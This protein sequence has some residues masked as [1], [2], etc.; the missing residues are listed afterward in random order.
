[1][2]KRSPETQRRYNRLHQ[3]KVFLREGKI[4][5]AKEYAQ[6]WGFDTEDPKIMA[7]PA[8]PVAL[9]LHEQLSEERAILLS[10]MPPPV[11][12]EEAISELAAPAPVPIQVPEVPI[13]P[14]FKQA[15]DPLPAG[16]YYAKVTGVF[17]NCL[18]KK[19]QFEDTG[20]RAMLLV[21]RRL[22]DKCLGRVYP[23]CE[24]ADTNYKGQ[25]FKIWRR[26]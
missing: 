7:I 17:P 12:F 2:W 15:R 11:G 3:L 16:V 23:V 1:M 9:P 22:S 6:K 5:R 20:D 10:Q 26:E 24:A 4:D 14:D 13:Y 19:I 25:F 21:T 18:M 8:R